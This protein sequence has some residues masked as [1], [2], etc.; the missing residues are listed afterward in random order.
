MKHQGLKVIIAIVL[1]HVLLYAIFLNDRMIT[2]TMV[3]EQSA[4]V[5]MIGDDAAARIRARGADWYEK[6][7]VDTGVV[8][9]VFGMYVITDEQRQSERIIRS[10][11]TDLFFAWWEDRVRMMFTVFYQASV[12]LA[13]AAYWLPFGLIV[14]LPWLIDGAVQRKIKQT[15]FDYSSPVRHRYSLYLV[16]V[17]VVSIFFLMFAPMPL[18]AWYVPGVYVLCAVATGFIAANTQKV[19]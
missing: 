15:N 17:V 11:A 12:R 7:F 10:R 8:E 2:G 4:V 9:N 6:V 18:P 16:E 13:Y 19:I 5:D 3:K 14:A 1:V